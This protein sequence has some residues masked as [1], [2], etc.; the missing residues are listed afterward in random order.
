MAKATFP[1]IDYLFWLN[2]YSWEGFSSMNRMI[3]TMKNKNYIN[4]NINQNNINDKI[5]ENIT[6][7]IDNPNDNILFETFKLIQTWG[8]KS[9]GKHTLDIVQNWNLNT[10]DKEL[11]TNREKYKKFVEKVLN[12]QEIESFNDLLGKHKIKGLSYSFIPKH[13][14][15]WSGKGNRM[16]GLPILDD[17]IAKII[18]KVN[19]AKDVIYEEFINDMKHQSHI[20]NK[21]RK[22]S[23]RLTLSEIEMALFSF[24][25]N[26][27]Q[28]GKTGTREFKPNPGFKKDEY[29]AIL[30]S[31]MFVPKIIEPKIKRF[32]TNKQKF[33]ISNQDIIKLGSDLYISEK[34]VLKTIK[35]KILINKSSTITKEKTLFYRYI[36]NIELLVINQ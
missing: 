1:E 10:S 35:I 20:I 30:I 16:N 21:N 19:S 9:S 2:N 29:Q 4:E 3:T 8:G 11:F 6:E 24:A 31:E 25:G 12:N 28:T 34:Y 15:F 17:V 14:C 13:I 22:E 27:W 33:S 26:Y 5:I 7:Y 18:Y 23:E 36:G 32:P